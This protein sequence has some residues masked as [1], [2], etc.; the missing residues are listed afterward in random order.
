M[1]DTKTGV[2]FHFYKD[3][4]YMLNQEAYNFKKIRLKIGQ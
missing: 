3:E 4:I 1:I 2:L